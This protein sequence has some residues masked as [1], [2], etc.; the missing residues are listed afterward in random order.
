MDYIYHIVIFIL[1]YSILVQSLN[2]IMGYAGMVSMCHAIFSGIGAY[3]AALISIHL[4]YHFIFAMAVGFVLA[5]ATG[6]ILATPFLRVRDEYLIV[7]TIGF[8]MVMYEFMLTARGITEGQGGIPGIPAPRLWGIEFDKPLLF[9]PLILV[10]TFICFFIAWRVI[11]SPFG[12]VLKA[13]REDESACRALGKNSLK[14]R[15]TVFA[16]GGGLAAIAGS[17]MA[18]YV[19]FVSPFTFIVDVSIF[20]IV[21]VVLGGLANFWG[22][23]VGAAILVGL[24]EALRF[25][26][27]A[28]GVIDVVREILYGLILMLLMIF[29][30]QGILPEHSGLLRKGDLAD[31][32]SIEEAG[33]SAATPSAETE[34]SDDTRKPVL[35]LRGLSKSFGGLEAVKDVTIRLPFGK[36]TGLIGPNGCGKTTIFNLITGYLEPDKGEVLVDGKEITGQPP[37][38]VV[39]TGLARSWQDV[40]V[41]NGMSVLENVMVGFQNQAGEKLAPLFLSPRRVAIDEKENYK[42]AIHYLE[43]VGLRNQSDQLAMNLSNSEQKLVAL[44]RLL[45]TECPVLLLD[46]PT[47]ALDVDSVDKIIKLIKRIAAQTKKTILL[48]EHNLDVVRGLVDKAYFMSEGKVLS[49]GEPSELMADPKLAE[50]YFGID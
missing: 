5:A 21:M 36:I 28:A 34:V 47:S 8:Q 35:E 12:R 27:G 1:L 9:L 46:E 29:R 48:V 33:P 14:F 17:T 7:F 49:Y 22:P 43:L 24:P 42:K 19:T 18:Y 39:H 13:I 26:P 41:F 32:P 30:P 25:I 2:L 6:A 44:A 11:H 16:L 38:R 45:A 3:A 23:L 20:I 10:I 40:R 37:Y 31:A 50:V 15:V 4:G